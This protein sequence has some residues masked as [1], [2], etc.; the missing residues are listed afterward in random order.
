ME[1]NYRKIYEQHFGPIPKDSSGRSYEVYHID[2]NHSN[3][4]PANLKC[5]T[6]QEHY[7]IHYSQGDYGACYLIGLRMKIPSEE[8]SKISSMLQQ[9]KVET[10]THHFLKKDFQKN[11]Q[12][13]RIA[14]G[15]HNWQDSEKQRHKQLT[16]VKNGTHPWIDSQ[17][18]TEKNLRR[19]KEGT[20]HFLGESNPGKVAYNN[21]TSHLCNPNWQK[22]KAR[23][24]LEKGTH[25]SQVKWI[26]PHC[27]KEGKG[28]GVYSRFHG[29]NCK[30]LRG[31]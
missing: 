31:S 2:G 19:I 29:N 24:Q 23:K 14:K 8:L 20:H 12:Q 5:V 17:Q 26:C 21:G 1:K 11:V 16:R 7:D 3:N 4:D 25:N 18:A 30:R 22:E 15:I 9:R 28:A 10:G 27:N 13:A 6:I